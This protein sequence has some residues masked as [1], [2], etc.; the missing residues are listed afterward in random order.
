MISSDQPIQKVVV[1]EGGSK[2]EL[3]PIITA[4]D[5]LENGV[6]LEFVSKPGMEYRLLLDAEPATDQQFWVYYNL[7][8]PNDSFA[9]AT[10]ISGQSFYVT[11][12][13]RSS[14]RELFEVDRPHAGVGKG[15]SV[16]W[17]WTN[18]A[19]TD[20][21][22]STAGS[23][24]DTVLAVYTGS[25]PEN[26]V[27]VASNDDR[28]ALDWTSQVRF[29]A[30]AGTTYYIAV[31]S[32]RAHSAG[33]INLRGYPSDSL[34]IIQQPV[35]QQV[36]LGR[37][38]VL[39]VSVVSGFPV[40][41]QWFHNG[42]VIPGRSSANLLFNTIRGEQLGE[43]HVEVSNGES[44]VT[45]DIAILTERQLAPLLTSTSGNQSVATD[46]PVTLSARFT[47]ATPM[48]FS[49]TKNRQPIAGDSPSLHVPGAQ[50]SDA[51][52][53]RVTATNALGS[54]TAEIKL[55]VID[56]PWERW[57]WRRPGYQNAPITDIKVFDGEAFA[58]SGTALMR[59]LDGQDWSKSL[60]PQGFRGH[61]I[62]KLGS[63][64]ICFGRDFNN[65]FRVAVS[66][67]DAV[68]W[69]I[70]TT[71]GYSLFGSQEHS[72]IITFNDAYIAG[73][74]SAFYRSTNGMEW[75][76]LRGTSLY[77]NVVDLSGKGDLATDGQ[78]L[79]LASQTHD[80]NFRRPYWRSVDGIQWTE[81]DNGG[82][83]MHSGSRAVAYA[84]G[85]FYLFGRNSVYQS[86]DGFSWNSQ[87]METDGP[88]HQSFFATNGS[89]LFDFERSSQTFRYFADPSSHYRL[90]VQ[91]ANSHTFTAAASFGT[92]VLYGT[93]QGW[94][95]SA[96][97]P[98]DVIVP[99]E[100]SSTLSSIQFDRGIFIARTNSQFTTNSLPD[101][102]SGDG[103]QWRQNNL[104]DSTPFNHN[105]FFTGSAYGQYFGMRSLERV[106]YSGYNPFDLRRN[107]ESDVGL[108][109]NIFFIEQLPNGNAIAGVNPVSGGN[110]LYARADGS[111][112]WSLV[113]RPNGF[114]VLRFTALGNRWFSGVNNLSSATFF[115]STNGTHWTSTGLEGINP[116][117]VDFDG[118]FWC[119]F[120][121]NTFPR[122]VRVAYSTNGTSWTNLATTG[123]PDNISD[124]QFIKRVV[125][126]EGYLVVLGNN[127]NLYFSQNGTTWLR[128]PAPGNVVDIASGNGQLVAILN[129][130]AIIQTGQPHPGGSAPR[131]SILS[132]QTLSAYLIGSRVT[133]EGTVDDPEDGVAHYE[134]FLDAQLVASGT[135][136][137][138][139]VSVPV[140]DLAGHTV[141][142]YATDSHGLRSMDTVRIR[143]TRPKHM[144]S[145]AR[146]REDFVP[147][148]IATVFDGVFYAANGNSLFRSVDGATWHAV[149]IPEVMAPIH[150]MASGNGALVIQLGDGSIMT[151]RDGINW[152]YF[153]PA[154][155][156]NPLLAGSTVQGKI[157]FNAGLF[158]V[159]YKVQSSS[160]RGVMFSED[161][162]RW[163][164]GSANTGT[165]SWSA[166]AGDQTIIGAVTNLNGV[167]R[168]NDGGFNWFAIAPFS[169]ANATNSHGIHAEGRFVVAISGSDNKLFHSSDAVAWEEYPLPA[170]VTQTPVLTHTGGFYFLGN[171][172]EFSWVSTDAI[173]WQPMSH[174]V[175]HGKFA[176]SRGMFVAQAAEGGI[177]TSQNGLDWTP[178]GETPSQVS[179]ILASEDWYLLL[180]E[181]GAVWRSPDGQQWENISPG[182]PAV[183][184][185]L[186]VGRQTAQLNQML[187]TAGDDLLVWSD[188]DG[189]EW[190][191]ALLDHAPPSLS[192]AYQK[193]AA[194]DHEFL[195]L[196]GHSLTSWF[197]PAGVARSVNGS[198][199][200]IIQG[201]PEK[202]WADLKWN[203]SEWMLL[204]TDGTILRSTDGGLTWTALQTTGIQR[205][206]ALEWFNGRWVI[207]GSEL[208][209]TISPYR[210]YTLEPG[211]HL[212]MHGVIGFYN[213]SGIINT[214]VAHNRMIVWINNDYSFASS[215]GISWV[216]NQLGL[217]TNLPDFNGLFW[218]PSGF[219]AFKGSTWWSADPDASQWVVTTPT[220]INITR[221]HNLGGRVFLY[222]PGLIS[223]LDTFDLALT[224]PSLADVTL[225][226]G[227]ELAA[228]V[229][230]SNLGAS[231]PPGGTWKVTAWLAKN[232][233][234]GDRTNTPVG[235][236]DITVP[237][238][239]PG[240]SQSFPVSFNLPN[241]ILAGENHL[242]LS[243]TAP[244]GVNETNTA[245]NTVISDTA[246][247]HI[248][249]WEFS[250]ATNGNGQVS[251]DFAAARYPHNAQVSLAATAGKGAVFTGWGGDAVSPNNQIT[252]LMDGPKSIQA[253]FSN[254]ATLQVFTRGLGNVSGLADLGSYP[255][256]EIAEITAVP[257]G[258]WEFSHWSGA[259][260]SNDPHVAIAMDATKSLTAHFILPIEAWRSLHF[261]PAQL[262]DHTISGD[263]IDPD[264]DGV[265]NWVEYLHGSNPLDAED[266]GISPIRIES[267]FLRCVY[268]RNTG[269]AN[270]GSLNCQASRGLD[271]W[272]A[273][274]LQERVIN[275]HDGIETVEVRLPLSGGEK[276]FIRF[277]YI[278][279]SP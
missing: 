90:T 65:Q 216:R 72:R 68:T 39:D 134:C 220:F 215:D 120:K 242:I 87:P 252:I 131:V 28:S 253:N 52:T 32:F 126:F 51:G 159:G 25:S 85:K 113:N 246:A 132:P 149:P 154:T 274:D 278:A 31:D 222:A 97:H 76:L 152:S 79:I 12:S 203:G 125:T 138:F 27:E 191:N 235:T 140:T 156:S 249:E 110:V 42:I 61:T 45:S 130:G 170:G 245:N 219:T 264:G 38:A 147:S 232:R 272:N 35:S 34:Q 269:A 81:H 118:K 117:F 100:S 73:T 40:T 227:D 229:M 1:F 15:N 247:I 30:I 175:H 57:E 47:G 155:N 262:A 190:T 263:S 187:V 109:T 236:F 23:D 275:T 114:N 122:T 88:E 44:T 49:W 214:L 177:V 119:V 11:G 89:M 248:P 205:G 135:G 209:T 145:L 197:G 207:M 105:W 58:I 10:L 161:G 14:S 43:Y 273:P 115:T 16:W 199:F 137:A 244:D 166:H 176:H 178:A 162:L 116:H 181:N 250:V 146:H 141:T 240:H 142:V 111:A 107:P 257:E 66:T 18:P 143:S 69:T 153:N 184:A 54:A 64:F 13:N 234:F 226:V 195:V 277:R 267:D 192:T 173:Q 160:S 194:S 71:T 5:S 266:T 95:G 124:N 106:I 77:G 4:G 225:G 96:A 82:D 91:P 243:L 139:R 260:S 94:I 212:Q 148:E 223:E 164:L 185:D 151:T 129:N 189:V 179:R 3:I 196:F 186:R 251:R 26:L 233:F 33:E 261:T 123:F 231:M 259:S 150:A 217:N 99:T 270:G 63:Q 206:A 136:N 55:T 224:L 36:D 174:A 168:S 75:T 201:L 41:Y 74:G 144:N 17:R 37:R 157:R 8:P 182:S 237:M 6:E 9:E 128:G 208:N 258:A 202:T 56:S 86:E 121:T 2:G 279:P 239:A 92:A 70:Q 93:N 60:F 193:L 200:S 83:A 29:S 98:Y 241:E 21:T 268:T 19:D 20:F 80:F 171:A 101:W 211:D 228:D 165:F 48:T 163:T 24:F 204:A 198:D 221:V 255:V 213:S 53:Y 210:T 158:M 84:M 78:T 7:S 62:S 218:T 67:D 22:I 108:P 103:I 172:P 169:S 104:L 271:H 188:S 180:E 46:T 276:G 167:R 50:D 102:Y 254:R 183:E 230:I 238:P 59:S 127:G 112:S 133:I 256:D 265:P